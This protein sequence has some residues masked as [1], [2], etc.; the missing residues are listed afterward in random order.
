MLSFQAREE[1]LKRLQELEK[2]TDMQILSPEEIE[3]IK[4]LWEEDKKSFSTLLPLP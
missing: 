2:Q 3:E 1:I 4:K